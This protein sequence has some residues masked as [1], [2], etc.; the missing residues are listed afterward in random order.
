MMTR[1]TILKIGTLLLFFAFSNSCKKEVIKNEKNEIINP[2]DPNNLSALNSLFSGNYEVDM[3][4]QYQTSSTERTEAIKG[5]I[6][7]IMPKLKNGL[8]SFPCWENYYVFIAAMEL[9]DHNW[10]NENEVPIEIRVQP[11]EAL[12]AIEK[13]LGHKSFRKVVENRLENGLRSGLNPVDIRENLTYVKDSYSQSLLNE[14]MEIEIANAVYKYDSQRDQHYAE[15]V[16]PNGQAH[17]VFS[18]GN[19]WEN[20]DD[21]PC[22]CIGIGYYQDPCGFII[23]KDAGNNGSNGGNNGNG[24]NSGNGSNGNCDLK[25]LNLMEVPGTGCSVLEHT[26]KFDISASSTYGSTLVGVNINWGDGSANTV[27]TGF[28]GP[29]SFKHTYQS[30]GSFTAKIKVID[31]NQDAISCTEAS[32][33]KLI[34]SGVSR[35]FCDYSSDREEVQQAYSYTPYRQ[36]RYHIYSRSDR[37]Y[38]FNGV[39]SKMEHFVYGTFWG[40]TGWWQRDVGRETPSY[41]SGHKTGSLTVSQTGKVFT[42][43]C[44]TE[45]SVNAMM[46]EGNKKFDCVA[47]ASMGQIEFGCKKNVIQAVFTVMYDGTTYQSKTMVF[48][49]PDPPCQ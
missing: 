30:F 16:S 5:N 6:N 17:S 39:A 21:K 37:Q 49:A 22:E 31:T 8:L 20:D 15:F 40:Q 35:N 1:K 34:S 26:L 44:G 46:V 25:I 14:N 27:Q 24:N 13:K 18:G 10:V 47:K 11:K 43:D 41:T 7:A 4:S 23:Q 29:N 2:K 32:A 48:S 36:I 19:P 12:D 28:V 42:N 9:V 45:T 38:F 3:N 33:E